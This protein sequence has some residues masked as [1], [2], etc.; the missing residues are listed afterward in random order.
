[1]S[2]LRRVRFN[3]PQVFKVYD[4]YLGLKFVVPYNPSLCLITL[5]RFSWRGF[6]HFKWLIVSKELRQEISI[7]LPLGEQGVLAGDTLEVV[8]G[9]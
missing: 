3:P 9:E 5:K 4:F 1:M 6:R 2:S 7:Y 8:L